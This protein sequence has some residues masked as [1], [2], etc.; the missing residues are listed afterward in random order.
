MILLVWRLDRL[1]VLLVWQ[2]VWW[3]VWRLDQLRR[4]L[5]QPFWCWRWWSQEYGGSSSSGQQ[6]CDC[7]L[8]GQ[9]VSRFES[10]D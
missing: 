5:R 8:T 3:L 2:L 6:G 10:V 7:V 1:K 4:G 9:C